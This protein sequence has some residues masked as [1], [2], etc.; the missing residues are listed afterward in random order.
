[1]EKPIEWNKEKNQKLIKERGI[2]FETIA[3][4]LEAGDIIEVIPG[5]GR[6]QHQKQFVVLANRYVYVVPFVEDETKIFLK[7]IIPSRKWTRQYFKEG[8]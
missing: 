7:T 4:H 8:E 1:M 2:S 3:A 6:Y 5:Y